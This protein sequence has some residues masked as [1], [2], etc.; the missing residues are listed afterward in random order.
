MI[1]KR[2]AVPSW[3]HL[4]PG[5]FVLALVGSLLLAV[6]A[7]QSL[8]TLAVLGPYVAANLAASLWTARSNWSTLPVLPVAFA[9]L[10]IAYGT[11]FLA[12][13]WR[14]RGRWGDRATV[15]TQAAGL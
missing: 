15:L 13:L 14:W 12:G 1:Q 5:A 2:G 9:I 3:R 10:H 7:G 4:V 11:G 8:W 6:A